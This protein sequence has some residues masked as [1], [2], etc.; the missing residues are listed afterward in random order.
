MFEALKSG[1]KAEFALDLIDADGFE[2]L[3]VPYYI[4]DGLS[5]LEERLKKKQIEIL[6]TAPE[7]IA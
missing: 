5:W 2:A 3:T 7:A 6:P 1:K 4:A